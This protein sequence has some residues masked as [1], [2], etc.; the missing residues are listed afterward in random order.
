MGNL[1]A[2][3][4]LLLAAALTLSVCT[5]CSQSPIRRVGRLNTGTAYDVTVQGDLAFVTGNE[6]LVT[7]DIQDPA[8][9]KE[10]AVLALGEAAIGVDAKGNL[11]FVGQGNYGFIIAD[12]SDPAD[13]QMAGTF[14]TEVAQDICLIG[15]V[16]YVSQLDGELAA[17][18]IAEPANLALLGSY[19]G[20]GM[21][22]GVACH[23]DLVYFADGGQGL[24]ILDVSDPSSPERVSTVGDTAGVKN[25]QIVGD[26]MYVACHAN[27]ARVLDISDPR[28]PRVLAS[29]ARGGEVWGVA[30]DGSRLWIADLHEGVELYD[31]RDPSHPRLV[32]Q[33]Q[34]YAP[35]EIALDGG[36]AYLADQDRGLVIL[37]YIGDTED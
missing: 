11:A 23:Q 4:V 37:E 6:G 10:M 13:P 1:R 25:L 27:G 30:G 15:N 21:G 2:S 16:A 18:D 35:H 36:Y 26:V 8:H 33:A 17:I 31:V 12:V 20:K 32:A 34:E 5:S 22:L 3:L 24:V 28:A 7:V 9:P 14:P 29:F 19:Q